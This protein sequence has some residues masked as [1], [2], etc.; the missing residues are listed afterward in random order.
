MAH[1]AVAVAEAPDDPSIY[2]V[3]ADSVCSLGA[4]AC[5]VYLADRERRE[6]LRVAATGLPHSWD[7]A[8][9]RVRFDSDFPAARA[10]RTG[11]LQMDERAAFP[12]WLGASEGAYGIR[13]V[14]GH[15]LV[16]RGRLVGALAWSVPIVPAFTGG[17]LAAIRSIAAIFATAIDNAC[18]RTQL[19]QLRDEWTSVVTHELRQPLTVIATHTDLLRR[20]PL[21]AKVLSRLEH[22]RTSARN[23]GRMIEDLSR[24]STLDTA[25]LVLD[26]RTLDLGAFLRGILERGGADRDGC[27]VRASIP[28]F[29]P[30][31]RGDP[32]RLEQILGNL[33]SNA[34]KYGSRD[35]AIQLEAQVSDFEVRISVR[36]RGPGIDPDE[37]PRVFDRFMRGRRA[38]VGISGLGLGLFVAKGLAEA[39]GGR[40]EVESTPG[41]TTTFS[42]VLPTVAEA[43]ELPR[44]VAES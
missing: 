29:L 14:V 43:Q 34:A 11:I 26:V 6:L 21:E 10:A 12:R 25:H 7:A 8:T 44:L 32:G 15:Q 28:P 37:L 31:V 35:A 9:E 1:V 39:Q 13:S 16:A 24:S 4:T 17:D 5:A 22:M 19:Q 30:D 3:V 42:L 36:N 18:T 2:G 38:T 20:L 40:L 33:L 27:E 23:L 41:E